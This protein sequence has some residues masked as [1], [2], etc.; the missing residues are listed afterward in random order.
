MSTIIIDGK[1]FTGNSVSIRNGVVVVDGKVQDG[2]VSGVVEVRVTEGVLG[3]LETDA[4]VS[5]GDV[6]GDVTAGGSVRCANISGS[7]H[8]GGSVSTSG[9]AGGAISAGGSVRIG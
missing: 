1:V 7:I 4:S 3:T 2:S 5:C 9:R 6:N 8:A